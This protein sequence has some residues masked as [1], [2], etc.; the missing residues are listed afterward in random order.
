MPGVVEDG[1]HAI[2]HVHLVAVVDAAELLHR[3][4]HVGVVIEGGPG[5]RRPL[6]RGRAE[7]LR[8][9]LRVLERGLLAG[10]GGTLGGRLLGMLAPPALGR[11]DLQLGRVA[12]HD[13][14]DVH[15]P[16]GGMDR[17]AEPETHQLRDAAA[18]VEVRVRQQQGVERL[19]VER[20][21]QTV[22]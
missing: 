16:V 22:A 4:T 8:H 20:V 18:M 21:A 1:G 15:R 12:Q 2:G 11:L 6:R 14:P 5:L 7:L 3:L 13:L 17:P 10:A 9:V 19:R